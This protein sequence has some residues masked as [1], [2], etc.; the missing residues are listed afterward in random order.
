MFVRIPKNQITLAVLGTFFFFAGVG[1][2]MQKHTVAFLLPLVASG[3]CFWSAFK[4][5]RAQSCPWLPRASCV[6]FLPS[7]SIL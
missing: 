7:V 6:W 5:N 2:F 3:L 1:A 4:L